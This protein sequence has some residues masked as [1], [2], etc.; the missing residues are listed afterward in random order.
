MTESKATIVIN[1]SKQLVWRYPLKGIAESASTAVDYHFKSRARKPY[2]ETL[3]LRL[4][5]FEDLAPGDIFRYEVNVQNPQHKGFIERS[6]FF[7]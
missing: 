3:Q 5:G 6:V 7:E 4:P 1:M 2:E